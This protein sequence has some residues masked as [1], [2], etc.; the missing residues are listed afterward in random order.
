MLGKQGWNFI[1]RPHATITKIFKAKYFP[2]G[3]FLDAKLG[4]QPSYTWRSIFASHVLVKDEVKWRIGD[5]S[6]INL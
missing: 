3:G 1:L 4:H 2:N 6:S 5:A